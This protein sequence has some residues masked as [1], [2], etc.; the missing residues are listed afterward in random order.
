MSFDFSKNR[1]IKQT[2]YY[3]DIL[4]NDLILAMLYDNGRENVSDDN[5]IPQV[6]VK[7]RCKYA[8][9][10]ADENQVNVTDCFQFTDVIVSL[11]KSRKW[12]VF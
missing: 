7:I 12:S 8:S 2:V 11:Q 3:Q 1:S 5:S 9:Y 10:L 6:D 4:E